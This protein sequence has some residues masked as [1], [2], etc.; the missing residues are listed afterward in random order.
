MGEYKLKIEKKPVF[1]F[2]VINEAGDAEL[3]NW[4]IADFA[5]EA[6]AK[7]YVEAYSLLQRSKGSGGL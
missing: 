4:H 5:W 1:G 6:D 7:F 3:G 2:R